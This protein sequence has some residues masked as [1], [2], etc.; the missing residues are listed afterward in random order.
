[1]PDEDQEQFSQLPLHSSITDFCLG[2]LHMKFLYFPFSDLL[3]R[4]S[5]FGLLLVVS[6]CAPLEKNKIPTFALAQQSPL[7]S[8]VAAQPPGTRAVI[9]DPEF[10]QGVTV[11]VENTYS[12]ASGLQCKRAR[13]TVNGPPAETVAVCGVE[14]GEW[15]MAPRVWGGASLRGSG[16]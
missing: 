4:L 7:A 10:G 8:W 1:M 3:L 11:Q 9:D 16:T 5:T 6:A 13:I 15:F 14:G 2:A 12:A